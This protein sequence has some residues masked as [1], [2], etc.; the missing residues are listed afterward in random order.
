[1]IHDSNLILLSVPDV[2]VRSVAPDERQP[3][4]P[5]ELG[6]FLVLLIDADAVVEGGVPGDVD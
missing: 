4:E 5:E 3:D 2:G 1:M 6:H